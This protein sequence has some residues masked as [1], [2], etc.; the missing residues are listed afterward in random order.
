MNPDPDGIQGLTS[1]GYFRKFGKNHE[2]P[3]EKTVYEEFLPNPS[4]VPGSI[5]TKPDIKMPTNSFKLDA[6]TAHMPT[7][8]FKLDASRISSNNYQP[9]TKIKP[10]KTM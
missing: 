5:P 2:K 10:I 3:P 1:S 7:N 8:T 9:E 6:A 4:P